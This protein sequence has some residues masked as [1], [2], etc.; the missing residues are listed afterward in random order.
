M[1]DDERRFLP[2]GDLLRIEHDRGAVAIAA[3]AAPHRQPPIHIV[4]CM[5]GETKNVS[6][7]HMLA[8]ELVK[9]IGEPVFKQ[10]EP[11]FVSTR[12]FELRTPEK[13]PSPG[14]DSKAHLR[15][16]LPMTTRKCQNCPVRE[17]PNW[18]I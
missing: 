14:V 3:V 7:Q 11:F 12:Q 13:E 5:F 2:R 8:V 18:T 10:V 17:N 9:I 15:L 4:L 1:R 6:V 16:T